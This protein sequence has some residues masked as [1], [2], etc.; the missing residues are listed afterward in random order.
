ME[1]LLTI[2]E[3]ARELRRCEQGVRNIQW[4]GIVTMNFEANE[5]RVFL[6]DLKEFI[7]QYEEVRKEKKRGE[8][9]RK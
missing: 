1:N 9:I 7:R 8:V 4:F 3:A 2:P 5:P 6:D